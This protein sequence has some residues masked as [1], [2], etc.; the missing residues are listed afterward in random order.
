MF[1]P[2]AKLKLNCQRNYVLQSSYKYAG[3]VEKLLRAREYLPCGAISIGM[4]FGAAFDGPRVA[5]ARSQNERS[6]ETPSGFKDPPVTLDQ[7]L[8]CERKAA[9][10]IGSQGIDTGLIEN[11]VRFEGKSGGQDLVEL[12]QILGVFNTVL[13]SYIKTS[14]FLAEG[15]IAF[16]MDGERE[17]V[18]IILKYPGRTVTLMDIEIDHRGATDEPAFSKKLDRYSD[19]VE[20]AEACA[21]GTKCVMGPSAE[22][23][24]PAMLK[25]R[26][27][28]A[29]GSAYGSKGPLHQNSGPWQPN[30]PDG[31]RFKLA[32]SKPG[33][34]VRIMGQGNRFGVGR[35]SLLYL[36]KA[37][38]FKDLAE[39]AVL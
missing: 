26:K 30:A 17:D 24:A 20:Y 5:A 37:F 14:T 21:F 27:G 12:M 9:E 34:V 3:I 28:C 10:N 33:Y 23:S 11:N 8:M 25:G 32:G 19:V 4:R 13:Q 38:A 15:K 31:C 7:P 18:G 6:A 39:H 1:P 2:K 16:A 22:S 29:D 36:K 35:G